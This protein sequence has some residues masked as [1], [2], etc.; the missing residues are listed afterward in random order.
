MSTPKNLVVAQSGG[1]SPVINNTLRGIIEMA[2]ERDEIGTVYAARHGIE[3]VLKEELLDLTSQSPEEVS[4]LRYT[5]AAGSIGTCRYKLRPGQDEDF[6]RCIDVFKAHNVGYFIYIGGNDSM[7]TANKIAQMAQQQG[8]DLIGIGGPKTIDNDVG[9][10]EFK[11]IDHTPGYG[12]TAKYWMHAV[13]NANEENAGSCPADPV[14]VMQA[15]GRR[16]G[17]IPAAARLADPNREMPLQIYLAESPCSLE[18]MGDQVNDQLKKDGRCVVVVSEGFN[19]GDIGEVRDKFNHVQFSSSQMTVAQI[20]VNY[21]NERGLSVK[22]AARGNVPGTDQRHSM[23]YASTVDLDEA[24][25]AGQTAAELAANGE[26]GYMATILRNPGSVYSVRYDK[27]P[28]SEVANSERTF[29]KQW[30]TA[31]GNDVTDDFIRYA[32]PL[33]GEGMVSLPMIDGRQRM[34]RFAPNYAT[35]KLPSYVPQDDRS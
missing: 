35:Q 24:Y 28:L 5:P 4:L 20:V 23:G 14:L 15:M 13:Q 30:I 27:V 18:Q 25:R 10:S 3:G 29:P 7:D 17:F 12:S 19:V 2:R 21:L 11:L 33:V 32:K 9:D 16:I 22:G 1:P 26:S 34:T 8:L 6:T 31:S